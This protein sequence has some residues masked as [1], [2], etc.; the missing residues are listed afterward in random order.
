MRSGCKRP[1]VTVEHVIVNA[2]AGDSG[3]GC[4]WL[5]SESGRQP[6]TPR[7]AP[8]RCAPMHGHGENHP[9]PMQRP[10][11]E[12]LERLPD[13]RGQRRRTVWACQWQMASRQ[14]VNVE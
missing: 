6:H 7:P 13:A 10:G 1:K 14:Q 9:L 4:N 2:G 3:G 11:R 12:G 5:H 8:C